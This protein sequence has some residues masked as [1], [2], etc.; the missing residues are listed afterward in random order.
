ML[1][2][3]T[4]DKLPNNASVN[5]RS[6]VMITFVMASSLVWYSLVSLFMSSDAVA[7]R[8]QRTKHWIEKAAGLCFI[9]LGSIVLADT[10]NPTST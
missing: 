5:R 6:W 10:R 4:G 8:F 2:S 1:P 7:S 3:V 9:G